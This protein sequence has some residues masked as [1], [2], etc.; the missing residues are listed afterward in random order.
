MSYTRLAMKE[1]D[2]TVFEVLEAIAS[3]RDLPALFHQLGTVLGRVVPFDLLVLLLHDAETGTMRLHLIESARDA[4]ELPHP[5][6]VDETPGGHV[7]KTQQPLV[8]SDLQQDGR[9]PRVTA[10]VFQRLELRALCAIPLTTARS[11]LGTLSFLSRKAGAYDSGVDL[12][13]LTQIGRQVAL[14]VENA[15]AYGCIQKLTDR[16]RKETV[17]LQE[18]IRTDYDFEEIVGRSP[19][20]AKVLKEVAV[21]APTDSTVLIRGETGTGK[22]LIARAI[23][24]MSPRRERTLVKLN[25]SAIPTGLLE[26]EL[27]GHEKGAFTGAVSQKV[28]RFEVAHEGT[29][30][31]DEI[32]DIPLEL[33]PKLL[34]VLQEQEFERVGGTR[35]IKV[36]VR[37]IAATNRDLAKLVS[38]GR[39]RDDLYYRLNVFPVVLPALRERAGDVVPLVMHFAQK[40][41]RR[42][43]RPIESIPADT[44]TE[45]SR[46][47]WPGNVRELENF[48]ERAVILST[49]PMLNAPLAELKA[50]APAPGAE[51]S[52]I[53]PLADAERQLIVNALRE[54]NWRVGGPTGAATRLGMNRT[55]L[56]SRMKKLGIE[57]PS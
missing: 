53:V 45:L 10:D 32:G 20:L 49:G 17:Y 57:R 48:I 28:G 5:Y 43:G 37:V 3:H 39:F 38:E 22:E 18:E 7:W 55:T 42:M 52:G 31:L 30:L 36:K 54:T 9:W 24:G 6:P 23:H 19:A 46:Y 16:L 11:R 51:P 2:C 56:Q 26:S 50:R 12:W 44:L 34:R 13:L 14:A 35:T 8:V 25:C 40:F 15:L 21:V 27:F 47:H 29:L 1:K 4:G 33:Q 41:G